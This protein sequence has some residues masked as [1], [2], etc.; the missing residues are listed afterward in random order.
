MRD[1][2]DRGGSTLIAG[3]MGIGKSALLRHVL[4]EQ[5][6][7][8]WVDHVVAHESAATIPF[9]VMSAWLPDARM[10]SPTEQLRAAVARFERIVDG[11]RPLIIVDDIQHLDS[12]STA[13]LHELCVVRG[14]SLVG[15]MRTGQQLPPAI[16]ELFHQLEG[17]Y[18]GLEPLADP[19]ARVLASDELGVE[20]DDP[21]VDRIVSRSKGNPLFLLELARADQ[22]DQVG[23]LPVRVVDLVR[24]RVATVSTEAHELLELVTV[25]EPVVVDLDVVDDALVVELER[26]GLIMTTHRYGATVARVAHPLYGDVIGQQMSAVARRLAVKRLAESMLVHPARQRGDA[27][28]L[29]VWMLAADDVPEP[30][31]ALAAT[32]EAIDLLQA[33]LAERLVRVAVDVPAPEYRAFFAAGRVDQLSG[34][35]ASATQHL[36]AAMAVAQ[37][38]DDISEIAVV[39]AEHLVSYA[40]NPH[41]A[42]EVFDQAIARVADPARRLELR[43]ERD[44]WAPMSGRPAD[45]LANAP[46]L[47]ADEH[48][49]EQTEWTIR[50]NVLAVAAHTM[51]LSGIDEHLDRI[52][53]LLPFAR[54]R[55]RPDLD[56]VRSRQ[57]AI[58]IEQGRLSEAI[59]IV[60]RWLDEA[61]DRG[62][63]TCMT[64]I[65]LAVALWLEANIPACRAALARAVSQF[66]SA[67]MFYGTRLA[68]CL[69]VMLAVVDGDDEAADRLA[70]DADRRPTRTDHPHSLLWRA[71]AAGWLAVREDVDAAIDAFADAART[72]LNSQHLNGALF[73]A[74]D[75][76]LFDGYGRVASVLDQIGSGLVDAPLME[77]MVAHARARAGHDRDA[78]ARC[79]VEFERVGAAWYAANAWQVVARCTSDPIDRTRAATRAVMLA[80]STALGRDPDE[81]IDWALSTRRIEIATCAAQGLPNKEIAKRLILSTRTIENNLRHIYQQLGITSRG[82]LDAVLPL[83]TGHAPRAPN[84][85]GRTSS[86]PSGAGARLG[87]PPSRSRPSREG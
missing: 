69:S 87:L 79:A 15:A 86:A 40:S 36:E 78:I 45:V 85:S 37:H 58:R 21:A 71:R 34:K 84:A 66:E 27:L 11:R 7:D 49:D 32:W 12:S 47:L 17:T 48:C 38:D 22:T 2:I 41:R 63:A 44:L 24:A 8:R 65:S 18:V 67:E 59:D 81:I 6:R 52:E 5:R 82:D 64:D 3:P 35:S 19:D 4:H 57:V 16:A 29:A 39:L 80:P 1:V 83:R 9:G 23:E 10:T 14:V 72:G 28:R 30:R 53:D 43:V 70:A 46:E 74:H 26:A 61:A 68:L 62:M 56:L 50:A 73:A 60:D 25:G 31:L 75:A 54:T 51:D 20:P 33:D 42:A 76:V 55:L 13:L 77:L